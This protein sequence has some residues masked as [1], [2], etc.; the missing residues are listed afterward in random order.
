MSEY[1]KTIEQAASVLL[2]STEKLMEAL[3]EGAEAE[4]LAVVY[5]GREAAFT[6]FRD[7]VE[8]AGG[9]K[10]ASISVHARDCLQR[11]S[12][13]NADLI[14]VGTTLVDALRDEKKELGQVRSAI[15]KHSAREREQPRL[16][17]IKA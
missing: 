6:I 12:S 7:A 10:V 17:T 16:V 8:T 14:A 3:A 11:I 1:E 4:A 13:F 15:Q 2:S 5:S 9:P